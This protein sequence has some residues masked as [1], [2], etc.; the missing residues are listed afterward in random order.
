MKNDSIVA[1]PHPYPQWNDPKGISWN[2]IESYIRYADQHLTSGKNLLKCPRGGCPV[3]MPNVLYI[4]GATNH[5]MMGIMN[6]TDATAAVGESVDDPHQPLVWVEGRRRKLVGPG[7]AKRYP[8]VEELMHQS[9]QYLW[10]H[11]DHAKSKFVRLY[12]LLVP[13]HDNNNEDDDETTG[14]RPRHNEFLGIPLVMNLGDNRQCHYHNFVSS[15]DP[16][17]DTTTNG[18]YESV[19]VF[20]LA[21]PK[22]C[23]YAFPIPHPAVL[24]TAKVYGH[25]WD[26]IMGRRLQ[27]YPIWNQTKQAVWRG[28]P[29]GGL[30]RQ[31]LVYMANTIP[32]NLNKIGEKLDADANQ[33]STSDMWF[34]VGF[35]KPLHKINAKYKGPRIR[36]RSRIW[37]EDFAQYRIVLDADGSSWSE[38]FPCLLCLNTMVAKLDPFFVD[39]LWPTLQPGQHFLSIA[40]DSSNLWSALVPLLEEDDDHETSNQRKCTITHAHQ[41]CLTHMRYERMIEFFLQSLEQYVLW[42]DRGDPNWLEKWHDLVLHNMPPKHHHWQRLP[43]QKP[44]AYFPLW[45]EG[46]FPE[47]DVESVINDEER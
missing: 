8:I 45:R 41:W 20:T 11:S 15:K 32:P 6:V 33:N 35:G 23:R 16:I 17:N 30:M 19:P 10:T 14:K 13:N 26:V 42:L 3:D 38:R 9:L 43:V 5:S 36:G 21:V 2:A 39:Y 40:N 12:Q 47:H 4:F 7:F 27:L 46:G 22:S 25:Q 24:D 18:T 37:F 29:T 44:K 31:K 1:A 28:S 34:N